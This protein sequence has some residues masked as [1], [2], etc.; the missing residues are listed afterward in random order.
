[1]DSDDAD[2][3]VTSI[4]AAIGELAR[5][6]MLLA[7]SD[8]R[9]RTSTELAILAGVS[10]STA[11]A[12]LMRLKQDRLVR[13]SAQ[14]KQRYYSLG[15]RQVA[16]ALEALTVLSGAPSGALAPVAPSRLRVARTC[17]DHLAGMLG[18]GLHDRFQKLGW[19]SRAAGLNPDYDLTPDGMRAMEPLGGDVAGMRA[20]R[21]RFA[22]P[23]LDWSE[24][25]PHI[26]GALGAA[27]LKIAL[28]REWVVQD[29][30]SRAL[31][32]TGRGRR[33]MQ[34]RFGL[35]I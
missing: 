30:D 23:C 31:E 28:K 11:S 15:S 12:H 6:R 20:L 21:R 24:R 4:A 5:A 29:L 3:A 25:R 27:L 18:V 26:G 13:M 9:A 1:M 19:L 34:S 35:Q 14:G 32:I 33:E 7:L 2:V 17:Y 10:A 8:G 22:F 16:A